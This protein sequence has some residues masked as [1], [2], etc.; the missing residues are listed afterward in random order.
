MTLDPSGKSLKKKI[1]VS[2]V[3]AGKNV[4]NDR[5]AL[6]HPPVWQCL[7]NQTKY[8]CALRTQKYLRLVSINL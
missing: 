5:V 3:K 8:R 1:T 7:R 2:E 6:W 4:S